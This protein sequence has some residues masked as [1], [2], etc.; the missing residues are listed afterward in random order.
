MSAEAS[1]RVLVEDSA[2][3]AVVALLDIQFLFTIQALGFLG[4]EYADLRRESSYSR[5]HWIIWNRTQHNVVATIFGK[6]SS[7]APALAHRRGDGHL[8]PA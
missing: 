8:T 5:G 6:D 2:W 1:M 7:S 4:A 3:S